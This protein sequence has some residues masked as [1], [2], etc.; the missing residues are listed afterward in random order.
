MGRR[1][2]LWP[3]LWLLTACVASSPAAEPADEDASDDEEAT[4]AGMAPG[5]RAGAVPIATSTP[6]EPPAPPR[7]L[8]AEESSASPSAADSEAKAPIKVE[9]SEPTT[10]LV[11]LDKSG[12]MENPWQGGESRWV[13]ANKALIAALEP[14]QAQLT[15]GA[16]RFPYG[17]DCDVA[18]F[19]QPGQH[20]FMPG[21]EFIADWKATILH[22][23]AEGST[24]LE[25]ALLAADQAIAGAGALLE[26]RFMVLIITDGEPTCGDDREHLVSL[27]A[28]W[29][30]RGIATHVMGLPGSQAAAELLDRIA[31]GGGSG[32]HTQIGT[33]DQLETEVAVLLN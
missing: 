3:L 33:P 25:R 20:P 18:G 6:A 24:P 28:K 19:D 21:A 30:E 29:R 22:N 10:V 14:A 1:V 5:D 13:A 31:N 15:V 32:R 26:Q 8:F 11:V 4:S 16:L 2:A 12:S 27:P 7:L 23:G 17:G 9:I